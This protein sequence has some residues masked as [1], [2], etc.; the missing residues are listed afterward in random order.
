L[1]YQDGQHKLTKLAHQV[2]FKATTAEIDQLH[3]LILS[4]L[5]EQNISK[6]SYLISI[7]L[8]TTPLTIANYNKGKSVLVELRISQG[9]FR[10]SKEE[11]NQLFNKK[12]LSV[13]AQVSS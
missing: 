10:L 6:K 9:Y 12:N 5:S 1:W 4:V 8:G 11:V 2:T 3:S 13:C 7:T